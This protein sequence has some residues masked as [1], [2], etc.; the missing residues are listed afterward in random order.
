MQF[1]LLIKIRKTT[2]TKPIIEKI[3][4]Q[5]GNL[6]VKK[7]KFVFAKYTVKISGLKRPFELKKCLRTLC[8]LLRINPTREELKQR[9]TLIIKNVTMKGCVLMKFSIE[10]LNNG[11]NH[12]QSAQN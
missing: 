9:K 11:T 8:K 3:M 4:E 5:G 7:W 6:V 1:R 2:R 12:V 10:E